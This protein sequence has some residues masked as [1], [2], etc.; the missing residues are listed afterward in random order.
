MDGCATTTTNTTVATTLISPTNK[1]DREKITNNGH[2]DIIY[3]YVHAYSAQSKCCAE[4]SNSIHAAEKK[5]PLMQFTY[6][7]SAFCSI[8]SKWITIFNLF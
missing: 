8:A 6:S 7:H 3:M 2:N 4:A 1:S 5:I